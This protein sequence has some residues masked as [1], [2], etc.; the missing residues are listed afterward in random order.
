MFFSAT[1]IFQPYYFFWRS[2]A[3]SESGG[4]Q[5]SID[6]G[7]DYLTHSLFCILPTSLKSMIIRIK[8][9]FKY[10]EL[11]AHSLG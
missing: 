5:K 3:A 4:K 6:Q 11:M 10:T 8:D 1:L 7:I 2:I 9:T